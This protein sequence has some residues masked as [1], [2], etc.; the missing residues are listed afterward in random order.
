MSDVGKIGWLDLTVDDADA[1][2]DFY[3]EV[4]GWKAEF[5]AQIIATNSTKITECLRQEERS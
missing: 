5:S 1:V 3:R 2:R 4:V